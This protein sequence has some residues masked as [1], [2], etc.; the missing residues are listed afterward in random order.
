MGDIGRISET[1]ASLSDDLRKYQG[2]GDHMKRAS[3]QQTVRWV[4]SAPERLRRLVR[5]GERDEA[6]AEWEEVSALL[7]KWQTVRGVDEVH[8]ACL[9]ALEMTDGG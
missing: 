6:N 3:Q 1:A 8:Q 7:D 2:S 9:A 4:L 5:D